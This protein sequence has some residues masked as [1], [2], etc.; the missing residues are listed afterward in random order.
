MPFERK[1]LQRG[2]ETAL[3]YM[4]A[5]GLLAKRIKHCTVR[6]FIITVRKKI[7]TVQTVALKKLSRTPTF[8]ASCNDQYNTKR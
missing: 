2:G 7:L 5:E 1:D 4:T 6:L 8:K 3:N